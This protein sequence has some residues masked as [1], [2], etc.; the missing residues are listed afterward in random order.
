MILYFDPF[1]GIS[2][3]MTIGALLDAGLALRDLEAELAKIALTGYTLVAQKVLRAG[4]AATKFDVMIE[5][6]AHH[7]H[8]QHEHVH[9]QGHGR[10]F[11]EI[12]RLIETSALSTWVKENAL[13]AFTRLGEV[14]A[15]IHNQSIEEIHF[16]E[17]GAVD[18]IV[19]IVGTM[20]GLEKL[21]V[22][23]FFSAPVNVGR[24][25]VKTEHG[26]LP[27]PTPAAAALLRQ[28]PT[29]ATEIRGELT[30]PTG[31]ALLA[32]LVERFGPQPPMRVTRIGYGAGTRT[33]TDFPNALRLFIG[34][35]NDEAVEDGEETVVV[36][37][38]N[39]DD[40]SP[41][42]HGYVMEKAL[43]AG[44]RDVFLTPVYMKKNRPGVLLTVISPPALRA[45]LTELL[46]QETTTIGV[47]YSAMQ[48]QTLTRAHVSVETPYGAL[49]VKVS[50][51]GDRLLNFAPEF[52]DCRQ[53][54]ERCGVPLKEIFAHVNQLFLEK[55]AL[56]KTP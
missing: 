54:A 17:V 36:I 49:R 19:D 11:S 21:G 34:E 1:A 3:D 14:E 10:A 2:G 22:R 15:Q 23:R 7:H 39:I 26:I 18:S 44:A 40:M 5:P 30:T 38:A 52:D 56:W 50:R 25:T 9:A 33:Y 43:G 27:V 20:V 8:S 16:H 35:P 47:R 37:E 46:F 41:Q 42:L 51:M 24:G 12:R 4:I 53:A 29:Y 32:T 45:A 13:R 31:A 6:E 55:E 28:A 48:R